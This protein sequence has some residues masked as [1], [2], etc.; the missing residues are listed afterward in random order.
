MCFYVFVVLFLVVQAS[1]ETI[2]AMLIGTA[3]LM[4]L[5]FGTQETSLVMSIFHT[6]ITKVDNLAHPHD[7][8]HTDTHT[9]T[10]TEY[11]LTPPLTLSGED[12]V[13][14]EYT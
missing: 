5:S 4:H 12:L 13:E 7:H 11:R 10:H 3:A 8:K 9:H 1:L 2:V 6:P 14:A